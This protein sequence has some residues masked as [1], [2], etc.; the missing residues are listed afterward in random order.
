VIKY[1]DKFL[2]AQHEL[3][4]C[5]GERDSAQMKAYLLKL[6]NQK[7]GGNHIWPEDHMDVNIVETS[8]KRK[9]KHTCFYCQKPGHIKKDC[10]KRI[11]DEAKGQKSSAHIKKAEF[12]NEDKEDTKSKLHKII[13]AMGEEEKHTMLSSLVD[14]H[15]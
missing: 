15:F 7:K 4:Q 10:H 5:R 11:A 13:Q 3:G 1:Q 6:L 9:E 14:E 8:D 2:E 12:V